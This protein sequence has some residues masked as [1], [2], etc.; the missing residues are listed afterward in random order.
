MKRN[1]ISYFIIASCCMAL[2][3]CGKTKKAEEHHEELPTDIVELNEEQIKTADVKLGSMEIRSIGTTLKVNGEIASLPQNMAAVSSPMGG[4]IVKVELIPGSAVRKGQTLALVEN[5]EFVDIQQN[6]LEAKSKIEYM[7]AD[8]HRQKALYHSSAT[9]SKNLQLTTSEYK[10]LRTQIKALE[11]KLLIIGINPHR[12]NNNN[13]TRTVAVKAPISGYINTVNAS[14][15]KT[16]EPSDVLFDI[17]NLNNLFIKLT[18]FEKDIAKVSKGQQIRFFI[19]DE[20]EA[21][22]AIVYQTAKC[23]DADKTYKIYAAIQSKCFNILPGMKSSMAFPPT[24]A[25]EASDVIPPASYYDQ[26][27]VAYTGTQAEKLEKIGVQKW[28]SL[29]FCGIEGW[30]E[31]RRTGFPKEISVTPP[32][33]LPSASNI[34]EWARRIPYP[35]NEVVYNEDQYKIAVARQGPDDLLTRVWWNK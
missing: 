34:K 31:W 17:V 28:I 10:A 27:N 25:L 21:H 5:T 14:I 24:E 6:Y 1:S 26:S 7:S 20:S 3:S 8:Y 18:I 30:S 12:L 16:V 4:R 11:Q 2:I 22:N 29:F 13:I 32:R 33:G 35:Q 19:N 15:G 23:I 9:S